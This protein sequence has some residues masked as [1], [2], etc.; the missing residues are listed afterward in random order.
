[1]SSPHKHGCR[2]AHTALPALVTQQC[3]PWP[4]DTAGLGHSAMPALVTRQCQPWS[5]GNAGLGHSAMP[6]LVT[7]QS[8]PWSHG[9]AGLDV[10]VTRHCPPGRPG[11]SIFP[12]WTS[13]LPSTVGLESRVEYIHRPLLHWKSVGY[14]S[15]SYLVWGEGGGRS[16]FG[17]WVGVGG[18]RIGSRTL[19][20]LKVSG[21]IW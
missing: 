9:S 4:H 15:R 19:I 14:L 13:W 5:H 3:R 2:L 1:M 18:W 11:Y 16:F 21:C 20:V 8:R 17:W 6:A 7:R 10:L 12:A